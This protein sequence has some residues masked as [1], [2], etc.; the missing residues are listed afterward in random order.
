MPRLILDARSLEFEPGTTLLRLA[1][2]H[3]LYIP[4][5]CF[6]PDLPPA[7]ECG[8]C[9]VEIEGRG[10]AQAC[11]ILAEEGMAVRTATDE[12]VAHR[13]Q[14]IAAILARHPHACLICAQAEG[15]SQTQCSS[16]VPEAERCCPRFGACELQQVAAY[17]G[18]PPDTPR[19]V[20]A[21]LPRYTDEPLFERD[22]NLCVACTRCL[23]VCSDVRG[24]D[25]LEKSEIDGHV[26]VAPRNGSSLVEAHCRFCG[27][28]VEVC[29]TGA[30]RDKV[31]RAGS[32]EERLLP[33]VNAC[34][35]GVDV[36]GYLRLAAEGRF[37]E[38]LA[39]ILSRAPLPGVL[40]RICP[41]PCETV[42]RRTEL[43]GPAAIAALKRACVDHGR[44]E[45]RLAETGSPT[46]RRVA[47]VGAGPAG[48]AA[49]VELRR[50][51][52][53]V[54]LYDEQESPGGMLR[55]AVPT[56]RLPRGVID[57]D[58]ERVLATGVAFRPSVR[59]GR[60]IETAELL[61]DHD[62]VL[63]AVGTQKAQRIELENGELPGVYPGLD[64]LRDS[65]AG[66][67]PL[68]SGRALVVGGGSV[69]V[70]CAMTALRS[71]ASEAILCSLE[72]R[73]QLPA[74]PAELELA[75]EEGVKL[76]PSW[77]PKRVLEESGR[78]AGLEVVRCTS[79]FDSDGSFAPRFDPT[80][81]ERVEGKTVILAIGQELDGEVLSGLAGLGDRPGPIPGAAAGFATGVEGL[82][83][84]GDA[85]CGTSTVVEAIRSGREAAL[86][87]DRYLGGSGAEA[88]RVD[89][90]RGEPRLEPL[91]GFAARERVVI[92]REPAGT[93]CEKRDEVIGGLNPVEAMAEAARCLQCDLRLDL[94]AAPTPPQHLLELTRDQIDAVPAAAGVY[95]LYDEDRTLYAIAGTPDLQN[96]LQEKLDSDKAAFFDYEPNEMYTVRES[97]LIQQYLAEH[98]EMPSGE[99]DLDDLF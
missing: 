38:A 51:G 45:D 75:L 67:A 34:P 33:C 88:P 90:G 30:L 43:G 99:D 73:E 79:V 83:A 21:G 48:L 95:R 63:L 39:L 12:V 31:A 86:A 49:A 3:D 9:A 66:R 55:S 1:L 96:A 26:V 61:D 29:P 89:L 37:D 41:A 74:H 71:G 25:V 18:I 6:H 87:V 80:T 7:E 14:R 20:P 65:V 47:I 58:V 84:C 53:E 97:E 85:I 15:C 42:C 35:A 68:L 11:T 52:H 76:M 10:L 19:Y 27:A 54:T 2:A 56:F 23:R 44:A 36:P 32:R 5:L 77:G 64:F 13:R 91:E 22:L 57:R 60:D 8:L 62:A 28:C 69:A 81:R 82:F 17:V 50:L 98:G 59:I 70:D 78:A 40:G 4:T 16:N 94:G 92:P 93:R 72:T 24:L 46:G